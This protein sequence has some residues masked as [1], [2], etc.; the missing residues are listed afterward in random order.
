M[1]KY[2]VMDKKIDRKNNSRSRIKNSNQ[3]LKV[4]KKQNDLKKSNQSNNVRNDSKLKEIIILHEKRFSSDNTKYEI[5]NISKMGLTLKNHF[6]RNLRF[7]HFN[8]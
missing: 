7:N 2:N 8:I 4:E 3:N 5:L 6:M 1:K